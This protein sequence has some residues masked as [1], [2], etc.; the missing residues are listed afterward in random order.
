MKKWT[1]KAAIIALIIMVLLTAILTYFNSRLLSSGDDYLPDRAIVDNLRSM[2]IKV[3]NGISFFGDAKMERREGNIILHLSG[4]PYE[5]GYQH[6][7]LLKKDIH[8]GVVPVFSNPVSHSPDYRD[9]P[10]LVQKL[11]MKYLEWKVYAP[12]ER[13]MPEEYLEELRGLADGSGIE[14]RMIFISNFLSDLTMAMLPEVIGKKA[15]NFGVYSE[16][17]DFAASGKATKDGK[18]IVGRNTDYSGQGRWMAHQT[19]IFYKPKK[20]YAYVNVTTAGMLKCNSAMNEKGITMGGHFMGFAGATPEGV[21]FTIFENEIMRKAGSID[22][23]LKILRSGR[24][25]GSFGLVIADGRT[26]DAIVVEAAGDRLGVRKMKRGSICLTNFATTP[27]LRGVDLLAKY[28]IMMRDLVGRYK[29]LER[30]IEKNYGKI[31][32]H[33][34]AEF[35]GDHDDIVAGQERPVGYVVGNTINVTS[36]VFQP[37]DGLFWVATGLEP[38]CMSR[39][40]GFDFK[41]EMN[42]KKSQVTPHILNG[43]RWKQKSYEEALGSYMAAYKAY[44]ENYRDTGAYMALLN[45]ARE[46]A[47]RESVFI[48]ILSQILI[49]RGE[50]DKAIS[51]LSQSIE[52][53]QANN[54]RAIA[55]LHLGQ[56]CDLIGRRDDAMNAYNNILILRENHGNDFEKGINDMV[57]GMARKYYRQP[58]T[59]KNMQ[60]IPVGFNLSSGLE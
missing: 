19:L 11:V 33:L 37:G 58:F 55:Y 22:E 45:R 41:S 27:E 59:R 3:K 42:G 23:A 15:K 51:L 5:M 31:T 43:Y 20:Q 24:I 30:L 9:M 38:A 17:S 57:F 50:Y 32:P 60:D 25:G 21:S 13:N 40:L 2:K 49:H 10:G 8:E 47:P 53:P 28:N 36:V 54:E 1:M 14:Y 34:G 52:F 6:G 18:L 48:R 4:T 39:Y 29:Q 56:A 12:I 26:G 44:L 7:K 46:K 16:C 35:M